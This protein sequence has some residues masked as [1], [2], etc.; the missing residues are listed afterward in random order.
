MLS[1]PNK[2]DIQ[3]QWNCPAQTTFAIGAMPAKRPAG[4]AP[5]LHEGWNGLPAWSLGGKNPAAKTWKDHAKI[6][7]IACIVFSLATHFL[8]ITWAKALGGREKTY[9]RSPFG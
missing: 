8:L 1:V 6:A 7:R 9:Q 4:V 2:V 3:P 5:V